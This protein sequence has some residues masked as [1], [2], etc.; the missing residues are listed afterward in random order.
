MVAATST[1]RHL[2]TSRYPGKDQSAGKSSSAGRLSENGPEKIS[3]RFP[4]LDQR[5]V[6][7][8]EAAAVGAEGDLVGRVDTE[9]IQSLQSEQL[10]AGLC[11]PEA[12][13]ALVGS[14]AR[15]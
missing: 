14:G 13:L 9:S 3:R 5:A 8:N 6:A 10:G 7:G 1:R 15:D 12:H 11:V 4:D 2:L